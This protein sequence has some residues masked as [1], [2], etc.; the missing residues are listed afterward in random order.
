ME[1]FKLQGKPCNDILDREPVGS[2]QGAVTIEDLRDREDGKRSPSSLLP[3]EIPPG[4]V[5]LAVCPDGLWDP[6]QEQAR[7]AGE[8]RG[9]GRPRAPFEVPGLVKSWPAEVGHAHIV[10]GTM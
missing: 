1:F 4:I 6:G 3:Q 10:Q 9:M 7:R 8:Q 5:H 2:S